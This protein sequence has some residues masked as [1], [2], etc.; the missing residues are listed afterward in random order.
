VPLGH[1]CRVGLDLLVLTVFA[2][3]DQPELGSG[4]ATQ[5]HRRAW[6]GFHA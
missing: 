5:R 1:L 4:G 6:L 2:P 3:H